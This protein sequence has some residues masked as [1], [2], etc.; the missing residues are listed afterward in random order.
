MEHEPE[1][2]WPNGMGEQ[3][4]YDVVVSMGGQGIND[5]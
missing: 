2:W 5:N 4:L 3:K 1:R